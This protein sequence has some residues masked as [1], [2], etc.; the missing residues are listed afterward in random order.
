MIKLFEKRLDYKNK[1]EI[2]LQKTVDLTMNKQ[3]GYEKWKEMVGKAV[4][5]KRK[6]KAWMKPETWLYFLERPI[7]NPSAD[8][9]FV[10]G[11]TQGQPI[12]PATKK[13]SSICKLRVN[14]QEH[15][16]ISK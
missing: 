2:R 1:G 8:N 16:R 13:S 14:Y 6:R 5:T 15:P 7:N 3:Y 12:G 10:C 4:E 11:K 9:H